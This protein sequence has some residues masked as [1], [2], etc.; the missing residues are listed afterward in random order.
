MLTARHVI[1]IKRGSPYYRDDLITSQRASPVCPADPIV[2]EG[3][4]HSGCHTRLHQLAAA[5]V[6]MLLVYATRATGL[7]V[8]GSDSIKVSI[9]MTS[10]CCT[11]HCLCHC[12]ASPVAV[13]PY[14]T[15]ICMGQSL[16]STTVSCSKCWSGHDWSSLRAALRLRHCQ[17]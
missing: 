7:V 5:F 13:G 8:Q 17:G 12:P 10:P 9:E 3:K 11:P 1:G 2:Q 4:H 15:S 6:Y 16:H 14:T